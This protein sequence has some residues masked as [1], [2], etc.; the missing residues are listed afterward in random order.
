MSINET[1]SFETHDGNVLVLPN[2]IYVYETFPGNFGAPPTNF[3]VRSGYKQDGSTEIA[4]ILGEREFELEFW[5]ADAC[6]RIEYW[7]NRAAL[8]EYFRPNRGGAMTMTV[9]RPD[10]TQRSLTVRATPGFVYEAMRNNDWNVRERISFRAFDPIWFDPATN[11]LSVT[12]SISNDLVFPITFPIQFGPSGLLFT[13]AITYTGT[14]KSFPTLR[15]D[16]PYT[17]VTIS[18]LT[19]G[20]SIF[21][22]VAISAGQ[23]RILDLMPGNQSLIDENGN[24]AFS[25]LGPTSNLVDFCLKPDPEVAGGTQMIQATFYGGSNGVSAFTISYFAKYFGI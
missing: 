19:T 8:L 11:A 23:Y 4:Y 17:H 25:D 6:N 5:R 21:F 20:I 22:T 9:T 2:S 3:I 13:Q 24:D 16:G 7:Q 10:S 15:L 12:A 18:N 14:W 1:I